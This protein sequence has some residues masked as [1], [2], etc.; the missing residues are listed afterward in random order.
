[1]PKPPD[2]SLHTLLDFIQERS[3]ILVITGA[4]I[5]ADSGIPTYRNDNGD[6]QRSRPIQHQEF[7]QSEPRRQ[8]YWARSAVGWPPVAR[9]EP[10]RAHHALAQLEA[11]GKLSLLVTQ[12]VDRLHQ[13]AG[14]QQVIDL[15]GRLDQVTC[16]DCGTSEQRSS[17]QQRLLEENPLLRD[18]GGPLAPDGDADID[19]D[20]ISTIRSPRCL[21]C[22]G[23]P[24]PDVVFYGGSVPKARVAEIE[25]RLEQ[26]DGLLVIGSSLSVYSAFRFCK[27]ARQLGI[28]IA[29]INRGKTRADEMLATKLEQ[30]CGEAL[31]WLSTRIVATT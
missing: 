11:R 8:R 17:I 7:I 21:H 20:I 5:S 3:R 18:L 1:M 14:H 24:M 16:L 25:A 23:I 10:N 26:S 6:W 4:G 29:A 19:D 22:E 2:I 9:A 27:S 13:R 12:N 28:P 15:H 31:E 30:G